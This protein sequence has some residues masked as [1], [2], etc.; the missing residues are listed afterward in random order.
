MADTTIRVTVET[1]KRLQARGR[2]ADSFDAIIKDLLDTED[3]RA[4]AS[5]RMQDHTFHRK[6]IVRNELLGQ[7][8]LPEDAVCLAPFNDHIS[9]AL[10]N[11]MQVFGTGTNPRDLTE[12]DG[13]FSIADFDN[14]QD[15][16]D[17]PY[18]A[19]SEFWKG[20]ARK[21]AEM[22]V[23]FSDDRRAAILSNGTLV[24]PAGSKKTIGPLAERRAAFAGYFDDLIMPWFEKKIAPYMVVRTRKIIDGSVCLWGA[25][26]ALQEDAQEEGE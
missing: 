26:I 9:T 13:P 1:H 24:R 15:P 20:D 11:R 5:A 23:F 17:D 16:A 7:I 3:A 2:K 19:F 12:E 8:D 6:M 10:Y 4:S 18:K 25:I 14:L 21:M 22:V